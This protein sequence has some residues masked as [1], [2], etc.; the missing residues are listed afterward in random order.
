MV[1]HTKRYQPRFASGQNSAVQCSAV[2][3]LQ[4][5]TK[6]QP[7]FCSGQRRAVERLK[8]TTKCIPRFGSGECRKCTARKVGLQNGAMYQRL[9]RL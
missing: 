4:I 5:T 2:H 7:R 6:Y 3:R 8:I 9:H 1:T